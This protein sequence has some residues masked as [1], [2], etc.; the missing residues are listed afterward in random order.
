MRLNTGNRW[1]TFYGAHRICEQ[2]RRERSS[3]L[4]PLCLVAPSA[5]MVSDKK[6][7]PTK[8]SKWVSLAR[9]PMI[10]DSRELEKVFKHHKEICLLHLPAAERKPAHKN[11]TGNFGRVSLQ[12]NPQL[13]VMLFGSFEAGAVDRAAFSN[14]QRKVTEATWPSARTTA[15]CS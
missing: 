11:K 9:K 2:W 10:P 13:S 12:L 6:V 7:F 5:G 15:R 8:D 1:N 14:G 4:I 3:S